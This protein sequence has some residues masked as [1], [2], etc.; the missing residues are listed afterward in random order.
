MKV[1]FMPVSSA[2]GSFLRPRPVSVADEAQMIRGE[3]CIIV[4][5]MIL[6]VSI[7]GGASSLR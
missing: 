7:P 3:C 6:L 5:L 4:S 2:T 1:F